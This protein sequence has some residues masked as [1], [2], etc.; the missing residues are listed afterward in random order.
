M[1]Q[2]EIAEIVANNLSSLRK[3]RGLTQG[4][5]AEKFN[6]SDKNIS[7]WE[8]GEIIPDL[9]TLQDLAD[10]YG[11]TIDY[12][13]HK[14][15][16]DNKLLYRK[17]R[18]EIDLR[19]RL[20]ICCLW[21]LGV[22]TIASV[23]CGAILILHQDNVYSPWMPFIWAIPGTFCVLS[24]YAWRYKLNL[25]LLAYRICFCWALLAASYLEI[26]L[27]IDENKGWNLAFVFIIGI[28]LTFISVLRWKF[29]K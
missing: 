12:L 21:I 5:L 1:T 4:E 14:P 29:D 22:W 8:R 26:G 13:T 7:R 19:N 10:F 18:D 23:A 27:H 11:V 20:I 3:D 24:S 15:T 9:A 25:H 2:S 16:T 17:S 28:P 6:Y